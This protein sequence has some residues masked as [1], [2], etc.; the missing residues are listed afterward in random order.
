MNSLFAWHQKL[1]TKK[2]AKL[3]K[4]HHSAN[5]G[6][7]RKSRSHCPL[8]HKLLF[9][10]SIPKLSYTRILNSASIAARA[11]GFVVEGKRRSV[12]PSV[13]ACSCGLAPLCFDGLHLLPSEQPAIQGKKMREEE[14][15]WRKFP[16]TH[17]VWHSC[18]AKTN[19]S[20]DNCKWE[21]VAIPFFA[22]TEEFT[23]GEN[24]ERGRRKRS[25]IQISPQ[26]Q[27]KKKKVNSYR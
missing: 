13:V 15:A 18:R 21:F 16:H 23:P 7:Q 27:S 10:P 17:S 5:I 14:E 3:R 24:N 6:K 25:M 4:I 2:L 1:P 8:I 19:G 26:S 22:T 9:S 20:T 12:E 11:L